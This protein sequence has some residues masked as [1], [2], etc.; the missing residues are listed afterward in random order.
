MSDPFS[1]TSVEH[2]AA[3]LPPDGANP[4]G[5]AARGILVNRIK[6][7]T[8]GHW[9]Q[10]FGTGPAFKDVFFPGLAYDPRESE[11][12]RLTGLG[13]DFWKAMAV[14]TVC[15]QI[16]L[17]TSDIRPQI[18]LPKLAS[19][20]ATWN[21]QLRAVAC[22]WYAFALGAVDGDVR[23]ALAAFPDE[24][25]RVAA[26]AHY[27]QGLSSDA[28][29]NDKLVQLAS[30]SWTNATWEL[31]HHW[32]KLLALGTPTAEID[33][34]IATIQAKGLPVPSEVGPSAWLRW[35]GW[36]GSDIGGRDLPEAV[37]AIL[38][39]KCQ[40]PI[41]ARFP[42]CMPEAASYEFTANSQPGNPYRQPPGGS[43]FTA[44][45]RVVMAGGALRAIEQV[46]AGDAVATPSG[47]RE[48]VLRSRPRRAG[49]PVHRFQGLDFGFMATQPF[50]IHRGSAGDAG[51]ATTAAPADSA[52]SATYAAVD[53]EG[54][55]RAVP[56]LTQFGLRGL[57]D[58]SPT[59]AARQP[60]GTVVPFLPP[61]TTA[62]Q[63][64]GDDHVYDLIVDMGDD[65]R[66][67]FFAG[68]AETQLLVSS[69]IPR[70][71]VAPET[72]A[73]VLHVLEQV[74]GPILRRLADVPDEGFADL[75]AI[76]LDAAARTIVP[77]VS[78]VPATGSAASLTTDVATLAGRV[79]ALSAGL[80][81]AAGYDHRTATLIEQFVPRFAPQFQGAI[82]LGW[83]SF[84]LAGPGAADALA[85]SVYSVELFAGSELIAAADADIA[86]TL[87]F[88]GTTWA[89]TVPVDPAA[90]TD[91][92]FFTSDRAAYFAEWRPVVETPAESWRTGDL[93]TLSL[94][95]QRRSTGDVL[96]CCAKLALPRQLSDGY[97]AFCLPL[98]DG[99]GRVVGQVAFD[100][101]ALGP[102]GLREDIEQ[103]ATWTP[104]DEPGTAGRLAASVADALP[105]A[106]DLGV[107]VFHSGAVT[108]EGQRAGA[109]LADA[110]AG[111][112]S[113]GR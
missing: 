71:L 12:Q 65:G 96:P 32:C 18:Q 25:S 3:A 85:A 20:L 16:G 58:G 99:A 69:E 94:T 101:R 19:A 106:F 53:P 54:L 77:R 38:R 26:R 13:D 112:R 76:G 111:E 51:P 52:D 28:W 24:G 98:L 23:T 31:F 78:S 87:G 102:D 48:V 39:T 4:V 6:G 70:Y 15:Q 42:T 2:L 103:R 14:A 60:D 37:E 67:E 93:W 83:R 72:T 1:P 17:S 66:S 110:M 108:P 68:D 73:V 10:L 82:R 21:G 84:N 79:T 29:V 104:A 36:F 80:G 109:A 7:A 95:L 61:A 74:S 97:Q 86:L 35:T 34:T 43:C 27:L 91:H 89:R 57:A 33:A 75:L 90:S 49:R 59:L 92:S 5:R 46:A 113:S 40:V 100:L 22:G 9:S 8:P 41:G 55:A 63:P 47:D 107:A 45:T 11:I 44:G 62:H 105:A 56:T 88:G 30:G 64:E 50:L 81:V